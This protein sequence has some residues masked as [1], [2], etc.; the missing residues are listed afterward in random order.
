MAEKR[1][2]TP[3]VTTDEDDAVL[4]L[5]T[6]QQAHTLSSTVARSGDMVYPWLAEL[7]TALSSAAARTEPSRGAGGR[8]P[9]RTGGQR[10]AT[11]P[12]RA[13][14]WMPPAS[15]DPRRL[16]A[17]HPSA[18]AAVAAATTRTGQTRRPAAVDPREH[19]R[20]ATGLAAAVAAFADAM[21][22]TDRPATTTRTETEPVPPPRPP[23]TSLERA[24]QLKRILDAAASASKDVP[25]GV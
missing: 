4:V 17:A 18:L 2:D 13:A 14:G 6:P 11:A 15:P 24:R 21:S 5:L 19:A 22:A 9:L 20:P 10:N 7:A 12:R 16:V 8:R 23:S 1:P 3:L 25:A